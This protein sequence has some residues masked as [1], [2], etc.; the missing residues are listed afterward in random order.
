MAAHSSN[1]FSPQYRL[2]LALSTMLL[3]LNLLI[4]N[5]WL[6]PNETLETLIL[7]HAQS[8]DHWSVLPLPQMVLSFFPE[9]INNI[10]FAR[11]SGTLALLVGTGM[12]YRW[13]RAIFGERLLADGGLVFATS[14][15]LIHLAKFMV[16]DVWL[17]VFEWLSILALLRF[18]KQPNWQW[19]AV[20]WCMAILGLLTQPWSLAI[21][22]TAFGLY[23]RFLH[24]QGKTLDKLGY[25]LLPIALFFTSYATPG[26][27]FGYDQIPYGI[28]LL[29][30][31]LNFL[32]WTGFFLAAFPD[33]IYKLRRREEMALILVGIVLAGLL[34]ASLL[35]ILALAL[36]TGRQL[37]AYFQ[38]NYPHQS[39]VRSG[40]VVHLIFSFLAITYFLITAFTEIG[41]AGFRAVMAPGAI[42]WMFTFVGVIGLFG[43]QR[44]LILGGMAWGALIA[45]FLY[46]TQT[47][48]V[49]FQ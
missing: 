4:L 44:R 31:S 13:G 40:A 23:L 17:L 5:D 18:L 28:F 8:L 14:Y 30:V 29:Y 46:W 6:K 26:F 24:P 32:P 33:A 47:Y 12:T 11:L 48:P 34:G 15:V 7:F 42:Y 20:F 27:V 45:M 36:L 1:P 43:N 25:W 10:F 49:F 37:S 21:S 19:A 22:L 39:L 3:V 41:A 2:F 38:P 9:L 35:L 16:G